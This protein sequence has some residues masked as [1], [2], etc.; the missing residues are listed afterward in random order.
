MTTPPRPANPNRPTP[1]GYCASCA[2][3]PCMYRDLP[4]PCLAYARPGPLEEIDA[5]IRALRALEPEFP[6]M[7]RTQIGTMIARVYTHP[8]ARAGSTDTAASP[9][10]RH[11]PPPNRDPH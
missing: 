9:G 1:H 5:V 10:D 7:D 3:T 8:P 11:G 2:H 4:E 6:G